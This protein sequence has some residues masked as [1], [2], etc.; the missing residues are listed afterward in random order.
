MLRFFYFVKN[1]L[2]GSQG[3]EQLKLNKR[4]DRRCDIRIRTGRKTEQR[5]EN[6]AHNT[7]N[8]DER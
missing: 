1:E 6:Q 2:C 7:T 3:A 4:S 5:K 8:T